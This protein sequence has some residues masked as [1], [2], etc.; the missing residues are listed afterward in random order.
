MSSLPT[1]GTLFTDAARTTPA[2]TGIDYAATSEAL[3]LF[4]VPD[5]EFHGTTD[6]EFT[7]T[8]DR[9]D[10]DPTPATATIE[11]LSVNDAPLLD[12]DEDDSVTAGVDFKTRFTE[13]S[14]PVAIVDT[15][16]TLFDVED[17][18][19]NVTV[20]LTNSPD[21]ADEFLAAETTGTTLT[22]NFDSVTNTLLIQGV[23]TVAD[24]EQVLNSVVYDNVSQDPNT[25]CLLYTSPSPRDRTRSRMPSSA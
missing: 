19:D 17:V 18:I 7:A 10:S 23:G 22:A 24:F 6:F 12:L 9:N 1:D 4:F 13:G 21:G 25:V 3:T 16:G 5:A 15:D 8:D 2:T 11:V 14:G 20:Q